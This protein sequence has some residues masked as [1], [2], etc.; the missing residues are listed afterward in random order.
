MIDIEILLFHPF[1]GQSIREGYCSNHIP[2]EKATISQAQEFS[3]NTQVGSHHSF[4][5]IYVPQ[6]HINISNP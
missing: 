6:K 4:Y 3:L 5:L 1:S 2:L